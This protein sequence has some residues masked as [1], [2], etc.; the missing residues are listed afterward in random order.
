ME[1]LR[2]E[3][4]KVRYDKAHASKDIKENM[5]RTAV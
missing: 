3:Q 2:A 5:R 4:L 1:R